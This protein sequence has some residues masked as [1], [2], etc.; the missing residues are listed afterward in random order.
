MKCNGEKHEPIFTRAQVE[1]F[2]NVWTYSL[3]QPDTNEG[4]PHEQPTGMLTNV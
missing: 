3:A 4:E 2:V 1:D